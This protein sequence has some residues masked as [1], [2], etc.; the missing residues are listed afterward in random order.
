MS[1]ISR[2]I[3]KAKRTL[4]GG[5]SSAAIPKDIP[6]PI[7]DVMRRVRAERLT[8][9]LPSKLTSLVRL[10]RDAEASEMP[11]VIIEA[12]CALGGSAIAL[13]ATKSKDRPLL[14]YDVFGMIPPPSEH[15]DADI[16]ERYET[17]KSGQ[18][19]GIGGDKYYGYEEGLYEKVGASFDAFG[20]PKDEHH[21]S[22]IKGLVQDTLTGDEPVCLAHVDVDWYEPVMVCLE[23]I[24]PRLVPGGAI[25]L[26]DYLDWSGCR[27]ATDEYFSG[28][29]RAGY[30]FDESAGH[31]VVRRRKD[32]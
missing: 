12:G 8:Y 22:L 30:E 6:E 20:M 21:V 27:K 15:D 4:G 18:S 7:A 19:T 13:C 23:R 9:L 32:G 1:F 28:D 14:V 11:G 17:I 24:V 10:C 2:A 31:L 16:H 29:R 3:R 26:D 25:V 5:G